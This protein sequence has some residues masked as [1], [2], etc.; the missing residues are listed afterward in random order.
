MGT[1]MKLVPANRPGEAVEVQRSPAG[2]VHAHERSA[3]AGRDCGGASRDAL[4]VLRIIVERADD[5]PE[6]FV[7]GLLDGRSMHPV[8]L[9]EPVDLVREGRRRNGNGPALDV[10]EAG[11]DVVAGPVLEIAPGAR[12]RLVKEEPGLPRQLDVAGQ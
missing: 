4:I 6:E 8:P 9:V 10:D 5:R 11:E 1:G 7:A 12:V 3:S 2:A